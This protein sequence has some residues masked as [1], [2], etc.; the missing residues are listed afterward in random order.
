MHVSLTAFLLMWHLKPSGWHTWWAF[1]LSTVAWWTIFLT[2]CSLIKNKTKG[3]TEQQL[4]I[5][6]FRRWYDGFFQFFP[7]RYTI[8]Q[9]M[10]YKQWDCLDLS[11]V[12][13]CG[14][15]EA[16]TDDPLCPVYGISHYD[17][18]KYFMF[19]LHL[20]IVI[21]K[22]F[23]STYYIAGALGYRCSRTW[24]LSLNSLCLVK[25][26]HMHE[27]YYPP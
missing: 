16:A 8:R 20:F 7:E 6:W 10:M 9:F 18:L 21:I 19:F 1:L 12:L 15:W 23:L 13:G 2:S 24:S 26:M 22:P 3:G 25:V 17:H 5:V 14:V 11:S 27:H 4:L